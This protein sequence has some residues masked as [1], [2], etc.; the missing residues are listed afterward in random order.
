ML[1][2]WIASI[3]F[4]YSLFDLN[5]QKNIVTYL[6][7]KTILEY[8]KCY[9]KA[10]QSRNNTKPSRN[11]KEQTERCFCDH[12]R[13]MGSGHMMPTNAVINSIVTG[14]WLFYIFK[15][16]K[17]S[18]T[19]LLYQR[20]EGHPSF[21]R[22]NVWEEE[23]RWFGFA[24]N[25]SYLLDD[26]LMWTFFHTEMRQSDTE[27]FVNFCLTH[28]SKEIREPGYHS[29]CVTWCTALRVTITHA[30]L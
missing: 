21:L 16:F 11:N 30:Q 26:G 27:L 24:H 9:F 28:F 5:K 23:R 3:P 29:W 20:P 22:G 7:Q 15:K 13:R 10:P 25:I 2:L 8:I 19:N 4:V 12:L 14:K 1:N 18:E 17:G 6:Q